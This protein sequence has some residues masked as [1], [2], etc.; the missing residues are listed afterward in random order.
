MRSAPLAFASPHRSRQVTPDDANSSTGQLR[1]VQ[2]ERLA[3]LCA[4]TLQ[5]HFRT[6]G[7]QVS[8]EVQRVPYCRTG[9]EG[10][11]K[12]PAKDQKGPTLACRSLPH[13]VKS[14]SV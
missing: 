7:Q 3:Y 11:L 12:E 5:T 1:A 14:C 4:G 2:Q 13:A 8:G 9:K 6:D 10:A